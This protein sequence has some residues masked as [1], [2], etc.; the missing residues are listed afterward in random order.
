VSESTKDR[1][2]ELIGAGLSVREIARALDVST[3]AV[4]LHLKALDIPPPTQR[5]NGGG[6]AA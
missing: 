6:E 4:Y 5:R 1:V 2:R 3:Q